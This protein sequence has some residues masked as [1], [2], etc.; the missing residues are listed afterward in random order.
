M[1]HWVRRLVVRKDLIDAENDVRKEQRALY[2]VSAP[3][4]NTPGAQDN[5]ACNGDA[6]QSGIHVRNLGELKYTPEEIDRAR[7]DGGR[8]DQETNLLTESVQRRNTQGVTRVYI[9]SSCR[10]VHLDS[11]ANE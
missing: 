5:C 4:A 8:K 10:F 2:G 11:R 6:D 9:P 7:D 3:T 1:L